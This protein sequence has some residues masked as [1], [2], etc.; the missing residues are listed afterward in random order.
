MVWNSHPTSGILTIEDSN[1]TDLKM[2]NNYGQ[3]SASDIKL[4][5]T[6]YVN[7]DTIPTQN[8]D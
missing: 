2:F 3:L 5:A 6:T 8:K 1:G 7:T 4:H